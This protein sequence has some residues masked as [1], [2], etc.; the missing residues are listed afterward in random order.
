MVYVAYYRR[1]RDAK[2]A[3]R[4]ITRGFAC[5]ARE[6]HNE[7]RVRCRARGDVEWDLYDSIEA[8][9][10]IVQDAVRRGLIDETPKPEKERR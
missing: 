8:A 2:P 10:I 7:M 9:R 4:M 6:M 1:K 5:L 3:V